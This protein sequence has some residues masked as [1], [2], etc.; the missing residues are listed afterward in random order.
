MSKRFERGAAY[1]ALGVGEFLKAFAAERDKKKAL[2]REDRNFEREL[3]MKR[4]EDEQRAKYE[5]F[6]A[7]MDAQQALLNV[8]KAGA[9]K[10][11]YDASGKLVG[12]EEAGIDPSTVAAGQRETEAIRDRYLGAQRQIPVASPVWPGVAT[13]Q[14]STYV[15]SAMFPGMPG[16]TPPA[17]SGTP[18]PTET[19]TGLRPGESVKT[20]ANSGS[21]AG[22][23]A[24]KEDAFVTTVKQNLAKTTAE[25]L[26]QA[27]SIE[28]DVALI[29]TTVDKLL[30]GEYTTGVGKSFLLKY[31]QPGFSAAMD[32]IKN[33][34]IAE[35]GKAYKGAMSNI[36]FG[37]MINGALDP[38]NTDPEAVAANL[39][40]LAAIRRIGLDTARKMMRWAAEGKDVTLFEPP[41]IQQYIDKI[42]S[43]SKTKPASSNRDP[44]G[45]GI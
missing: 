2:E 5:R 3:A 25:T 11:M 41:S 30:S 31:R 44:A 45:L 39:K 37:T 7:E 9:K 18:L 16:N 21:G 38:E 42:K 36:E 33:I 15:G 4:L 20:V 6:K 8:T 27:P 34:A 12:Y 22:G 35:Y 40:D 10:A 32:R 19:G 43:R 14:D 1:A 13:L 29:E 26:A 17:L 23:E 24:K 28:A